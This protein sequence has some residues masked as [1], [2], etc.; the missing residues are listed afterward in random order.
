MLSKK[1]CPIKYYVEH[2]C[3]SKK[4][5]LFVFFVTLQYKDPRPCSVRHDCQKHTISSS[6]FVTGCSFVQENGRRKKQRWRPQ[7][8]GRQE[9]GSASPGSFGAERKPARLC[10]NSLSWFPYKYGYMYMPGQLPA[11]HRPNAIASMFRDIADSIPNYRWGYYGS[12]ANPCDILTALNG[13]GIKTQNMWAIIS[14][15]SIPTLQQAIPFS[16]ARFRN[17]EGI[18][19][20]VTDTM[21]LPGW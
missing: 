4:L 9:R 18:Y 1:N 11:V 10:E 16:L 17:M 6:V 19:G 13:W 12:G 14:K 2:L 15:R 3:C 5:K 8:R 21:R 7:G 20:S